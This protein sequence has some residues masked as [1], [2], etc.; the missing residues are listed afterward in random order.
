[1]LSKLHR[2]P[3]IWWTTFVLALGCFSPQPRPAGAQGGSTT[4]LEQ[5]LDDAGKKV[6]AARAK[7]LHIYSPRHF[8]KAE[9]SLNESKSLYDRQREAEIIRVRLQTCFEELDEATNTERVVREKLG[10]CVAERE[11]ALLVG[12]PDIKPDAWK[13]AEEKLFPAVR[14]IERGVES[15]P[16]GEVQEIAGAFRAVRRET[17]REEIIGE[18]KTTIALVEK[19]GA[20]KSCPTML[21]RAHQA[22]G[23]AEAALAQENLE[24]ARDEARNAATYAEQARAFM[25]WI[26]QAQRDK[27]PYEAALLPYFDLVQAAGERLGSDV[28]L[29]LPPDELKAAFLDLIEAREESLATQASALSEQNESLQQSLLEAQT[30]LADAMAKI[31]QLEQRTQTLESQRTETQSELQKK[32]QLTQTIALAQE[33]FKPGEATVLQ[34]EQGRIVVRIYGL[35][36]AAGQSRLDK[37]QLKL[38]DRTAQAVQLF[39][40]STIRVEG[41]TDSDGGDD[42]NRTLSEERALEVGAALADAMHIRAD[43]LTAAGFGE[44]K[45]IADNS[46]KE[47]KARNRRIDVVLTLP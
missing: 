27:A 25:D 19:A 3:I 40:G 5:Q 37:T 22:I 18:A 2:T 33:K 6:A 44:A 24:D 20:E 32:Q 36:F 16:E 14:D 8:N 11:A 35:N 7:H 28:D 47:G 38:I 46:T 1:M 39:P 9:A 13:R 21:G 26:A 42:A 17:L 4:S 45:P 10:P 41:H 30:S 34:D 12:A 15:V 29:T 23:R 43:Q 31:S